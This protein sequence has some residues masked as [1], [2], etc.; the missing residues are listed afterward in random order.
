MM[1]K[2]LKS[3]SFWVFVITLFLSL[4]A[5]KYVNPKLTVEK[6]SLDV[7]IADVGEEA[8]RPYYIFKEKPYFINPIPVEKSMLLNKELTKNDFSANP[9][10]NI[11]YVIENIN[12][13]D[14]YY[15]L[16]IKRHFGF[17][18]LLPAIVAVVLC[19]VLKDP[20]SSLGA[21]IISGAFLLQRYDIPDQV[22]LQ[23][24]MS[25]DAAGILLLYLWLLG[26]LMGLW[27]KTGG[28]KAF[29]DYVTQK[30][31]RG[32]RSAKFVAWFLGV[33]FFQGGTVSSVLVG[34]TA[35]PLTDKEKI[36][37]EELSYIVDSTSSPIASLLAFNAWPG[38][39]QAFIFVPG[40]AWLATDADRIA[41]FFSTIPLH[42][43]SILA[44]LG[45]FL[46]TIDKAPFLGTKMKMAI[47]RARQEGKLDD[48]SAE[49]LCARELENNS[50]PTNYRPHYIDFVLP[51]VTLIAIAVMTFFIGGSPNVRM[52]FAIA[53]ALAFGMAIVR[54]M[55]LKDVMDGVS[56]GLKGVVLG[57]V[58]LLLAITI[59]NL[60]KEAGG[61]MYLVE[62]L[63]SAIPYWI[64]PVILQI[65]TVIIAFS[66][67]TSWGT[68]AVAFPLA[69]PLAYA[70]AQTHGL[71]HPEFYMMINFAA[72]MN[73][74]VFGDQCSPIS[75]TTV[76]SA[77]CTGCDLM[78]HVTTQLPPALVA[79]AISGILWT[80]CTFFAV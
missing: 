53:F 54:G 7:K 39:V 60:S 8:G 74:A 15:K 11:E 16:E 76:L 78:D 70:L 51:L 66:T 69:M 71:A 33:I 73:G 14:Q 52:A 13:I 32:P 34:T 46:L 26:G 55:Q 36:S 57:S 19:W 27:S 41:F 2:L 61:G 4:W 29:A 22:F 45:T 49:P 44:V 77:M 24:F 17:W 75:D 47:A 28:A 42:F 21:G 62:L 59:G 37:H 31:V 23:T 50:I 72:V 68:Y 5:G 3:F 6:V 35:K 65:L 56:E 48:D 38:Y 64:L 30:F 80:I 63:G 12:Q 40:V 79:A 25:Q 67:G 18:S 43:Y 9:S 10:E 58:I 20:V 1:G